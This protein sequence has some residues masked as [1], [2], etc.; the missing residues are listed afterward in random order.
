MGEEIREMKY[1]TCSSY[2]NQSFSDQIILVLYS[3]KA[4][5]VDE[6]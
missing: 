5:I 2:W 4:Q 1:L 6:L 3:Q